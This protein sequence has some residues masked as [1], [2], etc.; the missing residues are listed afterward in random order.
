MK[1]IAILNLKGGVAKTTTAINMGAILA[2]EYGQRVLL[3]DADSQYDATKTLLPPEEY[4]G[5]TDLLLGNICC[6][7]EV[8]YPSSIRGMDVL[9]GDMRMATVGL[10]GVNGGRYHQRALACLRDN[11]IEDNAYDYIIIDCPSSF[12][13][14]GC[15]AALLASD[16]VV[17]PTAADGYAMPAATA[18]EEQVEY[19]RSLN[20]A[21]R[22]AGCLITKYARAPEVDRMVNSFAEESPFYIYRTRIRSSPRVAGSTLCDTGLMGYSPRSGAA[23]DYRAWV[24]EY[25]KREEALGRGEL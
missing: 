10:P 8:I 18:L 19:M 21:L 20:P 23:I 11:V 14:P 3:V 22:V 2:T 16:C 12:V 4:G 6:Y 5:M 13:H 17:I 9:P 24:V 25:L 1:T 15:Q 7:D